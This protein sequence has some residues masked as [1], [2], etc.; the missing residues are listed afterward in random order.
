MSKVVKSGIV[1]IFFLTFNLSLEDKLP[2]QMPI[3]NWKGSVPF[4]Q[5]PRFDHAHRMIFIGRKVCQIPANCRR[6]CKLHSSLP[7]MEAPAH[8]T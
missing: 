5:E 1:Q 8:S 7:V 2:R 3:S 4:S 6:L